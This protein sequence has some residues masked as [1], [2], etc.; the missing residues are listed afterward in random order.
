[1]NDVKLT[2]KTKSI[3]E[4]DAQ[5]TDLAA[6]CRLRDWADFIED[7]KVPQDIAPALITGRAELLRAMPPRTLEPWE[8]EALYKAFAGLIETNAALREHA[9]QL[10]KLTD[11]WAQQFAGLHGVGEKIQRFA[12]FKRSDDEID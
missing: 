1:M 4:F 3:E 9:E 8:T 2:K 7:I 6:R 5:V 10:A 12:N 11:N